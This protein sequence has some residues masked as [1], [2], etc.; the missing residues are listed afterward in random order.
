[1]LAVSAAQD[2]VLEYADIK[3]AYL[4]AELPEDHHV[5]MH[6]PPGIKDTDADG[7]QLLCKL[8]KGLYGLAA[9]GRLWS[10]KLCSFM[11]E[12]GFQRSHSDPALYIRAAGTR[13]V[14]DVTSWVDDLIFS[15][16]QQA[17][18]DEF[19]A[20]L[21]AQFE[22]SAQGPLHFILNMKITRNRSE[23]TLTIS[24]ERYIDTLLQKFGMKDATPALTPMVP[25]STLAEECDDKASGEKDVDTDTSRYGSLVVGSF[26][27]LANTTRPDIAA[28]T[29]QLARF[30]SKPK[31]HHWKAAL[32]VLRYLCGSRDVGITYTGKAASPNV[33]VGYADSD[34][35]GCKD[36]GRSTGGNAFLID[37]AAA[38]WSS[39]RQEVV[40]TST[41]E[42]ELISATTAAQEAVHLRLLLTEMGFPQGPTVVYEDNQPCIKIAQNPIN[43]Q[44]TKHIALRHFYVREKVA[45]KEIALVNISTHDMVADCLT[46]NLD[47]VKVLQH[48]RALLGERTD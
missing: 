11:L 16:K 1:V 12:Q 10:N 36:T 33:L 14:F 21:A 6:V 44:R 3:S 19:K 27:Y 17:V 7:S 40:A 26:M 45:S 43:S 15:C 32:H 34:W 20:A 41:A 18:M 13:D 38:S 9:S 46:K 23:K 35:G 47:K 5:Y 29:G 8:K 22:M 25:N 28:S 2:H 30:L 42:A 24:Q 48:R 4:P 37:G 39:R 31:A